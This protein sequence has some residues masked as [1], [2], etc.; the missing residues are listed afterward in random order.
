LV[1]WALKRAFGLG[2]SAAKVGGEVAWQGGK[3][4]VKA[5][6][7]AI[8]AGIW[9]VGQ[10]ASFALKHPRAT[11][12]IGAAGLGAYA[13][14][15]TM[16][17]DSEWTGE[18]RMAAAVGLGTPSTGFPVGQGAT[19]EAFQQSTEGLVLALHRGRRS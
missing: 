13:L 7:Y 3:A 9:N 16:P 18:Q 11:M 17:Q 4:G 2:L 15:E 8:R 12:G 5:A 19:R 10:Y 1:G 14:S 6:P